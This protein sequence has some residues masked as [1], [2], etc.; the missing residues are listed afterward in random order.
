LERQDIAFWADVLFLHL[1][2]PF[3]VRTAVSIFFRIHRA[4][5]CTF[6]WGFHLHGEV[7]IEEIQARSYNLFL[8]VCYTEPSWKKLSSPIEVIP[9]SVMEPEI[10][11]EGVFKLLGL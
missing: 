9:A 4:D 7:H 8:L 11:N 3:G 10:L 2:F 1:S 6:Y 5:F